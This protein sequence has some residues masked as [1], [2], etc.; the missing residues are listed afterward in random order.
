MLKLSDLQAPPWLWR[1]G[2]Q[3]LW[4]KPLSLSTFAA[5]ELYGC[6][7]D[8]LIAQDQ[9]EAL[10]AWVML[11][12]FLS[13]QEP[14]EELQ[15]MLLSNK[16]AF[17][18]FVQH[19]QESFTFDNESESSKPKTT[20]RRNKDPRE[21]IGTPGGPTMKT[22]KKRGTDYAVLFDLA[23]Y[24]RISLGDLYQMTFRGL[25]GL[26]AHLAANPPTPNPLTGQID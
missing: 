6:G 2:D 10:S 3:Q 7:L 21:K 26:T 14:G 15:A 24:A 25:A 18:A 5:A 22:E 20:H 13:D 17:A 23:R 16:D 12:A 9:T 19:V 11:F 1:M 8:D 4:M